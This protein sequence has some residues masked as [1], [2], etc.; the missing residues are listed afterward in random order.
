MRAPVGFI[1]FNR[2]DVT[3]RVFSEI[4]RARP[5][6]LLVIADGPR[7]TKA[8]EAEQCAAARAIIERVDWDCE[9]LKNYSN[10]NLGCGRGPATGL[11][12]VFDQVEEAII[13]ED[14]CVPHPTF[15]RFCDELL[16]RYRDDQRVMHISG[17]NFLG[18]SRGAFSY[19][20]S[21]YSLSW[22]WATWR[23]AFQYYD[24]AIRLWPKLRDTSWLLDN[25]G[26]IRAVEYWKKI[27]DLSHTSIDNV[28]TWDFQ[29]LFATWAH[30]GL[31]ILP[32]TNLVSN[33]GFR[34]DATHTRGATNRL[35][36]LP[37]SEIIFPLKHPVVV[38]RN[39]KVDRAI[40]ERLVL[41]PRPT[42]YD[43]LRR[44][45]AAGLPDTLR[46]SLSLPSLLWSHL[47]RSGRMLLICS[48]AEIVARL[49]IS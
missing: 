1:I 10:V 17:N 20:F 6:K 14:D 11:R 37:R 23:R 8:G 22:G 41:P 49:Q 47:S 33:I 25:L 44:R 16:D 4:A 34:E 3:A 38:A 45:C 21:C 29:W 27:Y 15:F 7:P 24:P 26:D 32:N 39:K 12:W 19:S 48:A 5:R 18:T 43:R 35:A 40:F 2:P 9:V 31:S 46:R 42:I 30:R 36:N 28:N 13:L